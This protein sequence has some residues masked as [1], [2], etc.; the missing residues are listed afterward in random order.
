MKLSNL[1]SWVTFIL[2]NRLS[3]EKVVYVTVQMENQITFEILP[4]RWSFNYYTLFNS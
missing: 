3:E 1:S 2:L 4:T